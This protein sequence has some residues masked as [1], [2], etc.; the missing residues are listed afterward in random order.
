MIGIL[1]KII[2]YKRAFIRKSKKALPQPELESMAADSPP[3]RGFAQHLGGKRCSLI[4]EIKTASPSRGTI[5]TDISSENVARIYENNGAKAISV[6]TDERY[7]MGSLERLQSVR[8][9]TNLPLLRKDFIIDPYQIYEAR[10]AGADAVLLIAACLKDDKMREFIELA[11]LLS[12]ECLVE[13]HVEREMER[14]ARL[15]SNLIGINNRNLQTFETDLSITGRLIGL[16]PPGAVIVSESGIK[17]PEDVR[18]VHRFGADAFL[19]GAAIMK[20]QDMALKVL[21]LASATG[22][23]KGNPTAH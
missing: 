13:V 3:T 23:R 15:N 21:K 17:S 14:A 5:R 20:E 7:F 19:V 12:M 16:A 9:V 11:T 8:K 1:G 18:T 10:N 2:R 6:L 22:Y 4:A